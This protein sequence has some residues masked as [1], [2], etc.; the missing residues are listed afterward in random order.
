M[1]LTRSTRWLA[2]WA[3]GLPAP[4]GARWKEKGCLI[5][6]V[7]TCEPYLKLQTNDLEK[8]R[9][10]WWVDQAPCSLSIP[11][12]SMQG[13]TSMVREGSPLHTPV[14]GSLAGLAL[15]GPRA[16]LNAAYFSRGGWWT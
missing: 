16:W 15:E 2:R 10:L 13:L 4:L 7:A 5:S 11:T 3:G 14:L 12:P 9:R 8:R 1:P 6:S